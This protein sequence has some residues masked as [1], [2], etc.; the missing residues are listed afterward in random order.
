MLMLPVTALTWLVGTFAID[1]TDLTSGYVF[2]G[3]SF[4]L[5]SQ[6]FLTLFA[7]N[8][9]VLVAVR[10]R[11]GDDDDEKEA[12]KEYKQTEHDRI[13]ARRSIQAERMEILKEKRQEEIKQKKRKDL[14]EN[15]FLGGKKTK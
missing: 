11:F 8:V 12:L 6:I 1:T 4:S 14:M 9:E 10:V 5:G 13:D 2:A 3:F 15:L 7:T